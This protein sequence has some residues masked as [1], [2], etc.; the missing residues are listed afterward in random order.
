[1]WTF[2]LASATDDDIVYHI[3][4]GYLYIDFGDYLEIGYG[5]DPTGNISVI[6]SYHDYYYGYPSDLVIPSRY[7]YIEFAADSRYEGSGFSLTLFAQNTSGI[8]ETV[9]QIISF[10]CIFI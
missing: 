10:C 7:I 8:F 2:Q 5:W 9:F 6:A 3:S 1:M 4:Y